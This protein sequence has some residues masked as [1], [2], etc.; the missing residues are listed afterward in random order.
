MTMQYKFH[1]IGQD[2]H[3]SGPAV[4]HELQNDR[5][6]IKEANLATAIYDVEI[7]EGAGLVAYVV[8]DVT[9]Q[10]L[11]ARRSLSSIS[12]GKLGR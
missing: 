7:W 1:I 12:T 5:S 6:A 10:M 3:F 8:G 4:E 11:P 9:K 2:G